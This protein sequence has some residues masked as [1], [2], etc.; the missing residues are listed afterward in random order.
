ML[1]KRH[2][3]HNYIPASLGFPPNA[4]RRLAPPKNCQIRLTSDLLE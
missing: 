4:K 1:S 3:E 2:F